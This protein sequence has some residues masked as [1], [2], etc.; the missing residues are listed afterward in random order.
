MGHRQT[1][2]ESMPLSKWQPHKV[3]ESRIPPQVPERD[4]DESE[5]YYLRDIDINP[6][7][8]RAPR[9]NPVGN[10]GSEMG[11]GSTTNSSTDE[12]GYLILT[13]DDKEAIAHYKNT[14]ESESST[15][16]NLCKMD[17]QEQLYSEVVSNSAAHPILLATGSWSPFH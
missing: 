1:S 9:P 10:S 11:S 16:A 17:M 15:G 13:Q 2:A 14:Q 3:K 6:G 12:N 4:R 5:S 7:P 8:V